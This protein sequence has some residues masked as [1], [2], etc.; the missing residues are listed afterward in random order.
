LLKLSPEKPSPT[1]QARPGP[2]VGPFHWQNRR[3]RVPEL[4][5]LFTFPDDFELIGSRSSIQ[6]QLGNSVPALLGEKVMKAM[7]GERE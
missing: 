6:A 1:I 5:R 3:L 7:I 4:K 2:Y